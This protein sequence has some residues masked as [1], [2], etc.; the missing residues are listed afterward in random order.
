M[1][2]CFPHISIHRFRG[3]YAVLLC[4]TIWGNDYHNTKQKGLCCLRTS[5]LLANRVF[6]RQLIKV[7]FQ[8][9]TKKLSY[10]V[11]VATYVCGRHRCI[12]EEAELHSPA[13]S[14]EKTFT[15]YIVLIEPN[16]YFGLTDSRTH[17]L[18]DSSVVPWFRISVAP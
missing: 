10:P 4:K 3:C 18:T 12:K 2:F 1:L 11:P 5:L 13:S 15:L 14:N 16:K 6:G 7:C 17:G 8:N 9:L